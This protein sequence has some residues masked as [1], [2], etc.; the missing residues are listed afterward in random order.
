MSK[1]LCLNCEIQF[2]QKVDWQLFCEEKCKKEYWYKT[3]HVACTKCNH[4]FRLNE[5]KFKSPKDYYKWRLQNV[6]TQE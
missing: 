1:E 5:N 2:D 4:V 6:T 3:K